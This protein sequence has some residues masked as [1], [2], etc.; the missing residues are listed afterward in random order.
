M[1]KTDT[2]YKL[3]IEDYKKRRV[4]WTMQNFNSHY[5]LKRHR[6]FH[7]LFSQIKY[8]IQNAPLTEQGRRKNF[9]N[10]YAESRFDK[11]GNRLFVKVIINYSKNPA[12]V[13]TAYLTNNYGEATINLRK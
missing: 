6:D 4:V 12:E 8:A 3:E 5:S 10:L 1:N 11:N 9:E 7:K 13:K 2:K